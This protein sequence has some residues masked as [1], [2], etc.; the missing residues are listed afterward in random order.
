MATNGLIMEN[1]GKLLSKTLTNPTGEIL[2]NYA[3]DP[4]R[5]LIEVIQFRQWSGILEGRFRA[6]WG[7]AKNELVGVARWN[8]AAWGRAA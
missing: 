6:Y 1:G 4:E 8:N 2:I 5:T 3:R 7:H